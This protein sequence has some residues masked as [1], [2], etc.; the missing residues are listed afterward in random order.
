M[1]EDKEPVFDACDT[2]KLCLRVFAPMLASISFKPENM[3]RAAAKGFLNATDCA[4]YLVKKG[5]AFREAYGIVGRLVRHCIEKNLTLETL[6]L[7]EYKAVSG[8][9]AEDVYDALKLENCVNARKITGGP[10][11][12]AVKEHIEKIREFYNEHKSL[13]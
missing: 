11:P 10:A 2:M 5:L 6:P 7:E 8:L 1:Q 13:Y 9:F 12:D 4:D 3:R